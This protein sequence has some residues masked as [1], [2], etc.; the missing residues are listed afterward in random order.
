MRISTSIIITLCNFIGFNCFGQQNTPRAPSAAV[1][2]YSKYADTPPDLFTGAMSEQIPLDSVSAG[3]LSHSVGLNYYFAGHRPS[4]LSS[5]VGLGFQLMAGGAITRQVLGR[6]NFGAR[7]WNNEGAQINNGLT[8]SEQHDIVDD[9]L[10][11]QADIYSVSVG[12]L[13]IK[14][15]MDHLGEFHT[16]PRS[17]LD[18]SYYTKSYFYFGATRYYNY[19]LLLDTQGNKYYFGDKFEGINLEHSTYTERTFYEDENYIS[20]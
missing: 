13:N 18:I 15:A 14:F 9:K 20:V 19:F 10:D 11:S 7:G 16:I 8:S 4:D 6:V 5:T 1:Y 17:D 12:G 2:N 3:P